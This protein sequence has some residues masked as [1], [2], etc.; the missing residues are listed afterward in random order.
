MGGK[1]MKTLF[2]FFVISITFNSNLFAQY[3]IGQDKID[4]LKNK[5]ENS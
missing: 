5:K 4:L 1:K 3:Y 2:L